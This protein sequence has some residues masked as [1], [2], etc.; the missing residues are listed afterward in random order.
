MIRSSVLPRRW[1]AT[2]LPSLLALLLLAA[3]VPIQAPSAATVPAPAAEAPAVAPAAVQAADAFAG[4]WTGSIAIAGIELAVDLHMAQEGGGY[5]ATL[6]I[7]QQ[8]AMGLP[9]GNLEV[10]LPNVRFTILDGAQQASFD[11]ALDGD[12]TIAGVFA[13]AGQE[14]A[15]ALARTDRAPAE[16]VAPAAEASGIS[17]IYT[18]PSGLWSVPVPTSWTVTPQEGFVT[19]QDPEQQITVYLLT[20]TT[21]DQAIAIADAWQFAQPGFDLPIDQTVTPPAPEGVEELLV[22]SYDTGDDNRIVQAAALLFGGV[23]YV[24]LYDVTLE[25]AQRRGAQLSIIDSGFNILAR[26][27]L[28][29]A[30]VQ[31]AEM[32]DEIIATWEAFI[33]DAQAK[34]EVP[35]A[36]LGVVRGGELVYEKAFGFSDSETQTPMRTDMQMM[37]GSTSKSFA[38]MMMGTLVDDGLMTW[39]TPA[40]QLYPAFAVRDPDLSKTITMRNLVCACTG[41]PRRDF[42]FLMN[43]NELSATDVISSL[44]TFE[45]FTRFGEAFQYSNQMVATAGYIAGL[46]AEP[47]MSDPDAAYTKALRERVIGPIGMEN[48]TLSFEDVT[49]RGEYAT[50]HAYNAHSEYVP[51]PLTV[52]E[53]LQPIAPAGGL[54]STLD[55]MAK[56]MVTQLSTGVAPDGTRV[57]SEEN[58]LVTRE[59][60]VKMSAEVSYGLGWLVGEYKG[61]PMI[62][63]GGNTMGFTSDFAFLPTADL[64]IIV[65]TN[66]QGTNSF[67]GAVRIRLLELLYGVPSEVEPN[68][69]F[70]LD[71][72]TEQR[73]KAAEQLSG[74]LDEA[75]VAP[76]VG[77]YGSA[78]VGRLEMSLEDGKLMADF[79]EF[80]TSIVPKTDDKGEPDNY[81]AFDPPL[82]GF[83]FKLQ[84]TDDGTPNVII[85]EGLTEYTFAPVQ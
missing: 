31:P 65:L 18:D 22:Y 58:L 34:F 19:L 16:A 77:S 61:L 24:Q 1:G 83:P 51:I 79:G 69:Q 73:A 55:D 3:C 33:G 43:A 85:G 63:H 57:V 37:I 46:A 6:D 64:G 72:I 62:E 21:V 39:D 59:P 48:T 80:V 11:G 42:E 74:A 25:A 52:E 35:G 8:N 15:F 76:F 10:N 7:P 12:G 75:A 23:N 40:Q 49:A 20:S 50:P 38:T 2:L 44:S 13:Q 78:T 81:V 14:G 17:E 66:G 68:V 54:W 5:N 41:V 36:L 27:R 60:Q 30:D 28:N 84:M 53:T 29:L 71:R 56:Y 26:E 47:G 70:M 82:A 32:T 4:D 9:V 45:F 67:S